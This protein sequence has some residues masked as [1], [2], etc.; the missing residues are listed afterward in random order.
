MEA[1]SKQID[2]D[3]LDSIIKRCEASMVSPWKKKP[4]PEPE[5]KAAPEEPKSD[6]DDMD[7]EDLMRT[8]EEI[9]GK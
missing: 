2:L 4:A 8:Y 3:N 6:L 1:D 9:K 7:L 5:A